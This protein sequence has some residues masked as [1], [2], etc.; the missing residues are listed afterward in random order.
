ML[1]SKP[2]VIADDTWAKILWAGLNLGADDLTV[3]GVRAYPFELVRALALTWLFAGQRSDEIVRLRVGCVRWQPGD[4]AGADTAPVCLLDVPVHKTG[5]AFTKPVD[6]LLG[7]A[8]E[9]WETA[10]PAQP[11]MTDR[12][13]GEA[14]AFLLGPPFCSP[15][16]PT[17]WPTR[18]S[19]RR[20]SRCSAA[21]QESRPATP[22]A[23]SPATAPARPSPA[24]STTPRSR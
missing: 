14:A 6:P 15:A 1:G 13:T 12:K 11:P 22:A 2:R 19:T 17:R 8:I 21:R 5:A 24:S 23:A 18:T 16:A 4:V 20:S 7:H 10:R 9:A 3:S